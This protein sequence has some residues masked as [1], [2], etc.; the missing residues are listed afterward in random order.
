MIESF[1]RQ[2]YR[3]LPLV[4]LLLPSAL[5]AFGP[6]GREHI[7][8]IQDA[9]VSGHRLTARA[10]IL[11]PMPS[12]FTSLQVWL[13]VVVNVEGRVE[14]AEAWNSGGLY[15]QWA[16]DQAETAEHQQ[17]FRPF[18]RH[19]HPIRVIFDDCVWIVPP[20][21]WAAAHVAFPDIV[22]MKSLRMTIQRTG[23]YGI[24]PTYSIEV[25]GNGEVFFSGEQNVPA[26]GHF[27]SHVSQAIVD[28]LLSCFRKADYLSLKDE[29]VAMIT[30]NPTCITSIQFD[31]VRKSVKDY[32]GFAAGMPENLWQVEREMDQ[33][34]REKR[35]ID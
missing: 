5:F 17:Q 25:R 33:I 31:T 29:Y 35:W 6:I 1:V 26:T 8:N 28:H 23:C 32:V 21:E 7:R 4:L 9:E 13:H 30:D 34:A 20:V 24:C 2:L 19:G 16:K 14:S 10:I 15:P 11:E 18:E 27:H 22:D 3:D 12:G